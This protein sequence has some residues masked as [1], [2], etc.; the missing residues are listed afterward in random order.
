MKRRT[1]AKG[2]TLVELLVTIVIIAALVAASFVGVTCVRNR[3][4]S[5]VEIGAAR[6]LIAGYL[7]YAADNN[8]N[9]LPGFKEDPTATNLEGKLV[10]YPAN[11]R[12]A[13]R[14]APSVPSVKGVILYNGNED[15][16]LKNDPDYRASVYSNM[17]INAVFVGGHFGKSSPLDAGRDKLIAAYGKFFAGTL[18]EV[19]DPSRLIAFASARHIEDGEKVPGYFQV[20]PPNITGKVWS[21]G[22]FSADSDPASHGFVDFRWS[23]KALVAMVGGNIEMLGEEE[24]R[25]M[26]RWSN[27]ASRAN[28]RDFVVTQTQQ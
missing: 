5:A 7:T 15:Q 14:L 17:G 22:K 2:F 4:K 20:S 23:S 1:R 24:L 25:D 9:L 10:G 8:G 6:N 19:D 12:Y 11:A 28:S 3:S 27:Q 18:A 16:L 13:W 21:S 26:R